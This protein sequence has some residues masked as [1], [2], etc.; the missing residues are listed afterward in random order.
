MPSESEPRQP[1][2]TNA[3]PPGR[4]FPCEKCGAKLDFDPASRSLQCPYCGHTQAIEPSKARVHKHDLES[5]LEKGGDGTVLE[6]RSSQVTCTAC[7]AVVLLEDKVVTDKCPYC[8][9]H[10][11]NK[12]EAAKAMIAPE[13]VIP[14]AITSRQAIEAYDRWLKGL[15]FAPNALRHVATLGQ[16]SGAYVPFWTFDSMTYTHYT[17]QRGEDYTETETYTETNAQGQTETKTRQVTKTRWYHVSGEVQH[18]FQ[19]I[20]ICASKGVPEHYARTLRPRDLKAL[21]AFRSEFLSGFKTERYTIGPSD[22]FEEAKQ[23]MDGEIRELC[24]RDIGGD[25]QRVESVNTQHVGVTYKHILLP[26]W[27]ASYRY[28]E[29]SYRVLV[30][31]QTG[32]VLGDR[33]YSWV[34]IAILVAV[35]LAA[36]LAAF[37]LFT[38]LARGAM[39]EQ[40]KANRACYSPSAALSESK[41]PFVHCHIVHSIYSLLLDFLPSHP[42]KATF[43]LESWSGLV[44]RA[45]QRS[46]PTGRLVPISPERRAPCAPVST[47][48]FSTLPWRS[49]EHCWE[50]RP[51]WEPDIPRP[52]MKQLLP[53]RAS[54]WPNLRSAAWA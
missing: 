44:I 27:L 9:T 15:W 30:N 45:S 29:K 50:R 51:R 38:S 54:K 12:P 53:S 28:Q 13:G 31:G 17:G 7:G 3:P 46:G 2:I 14:F 39:V 19:D 41:Q 35:I 21:E 10:L 18:F 32:E 25:H 22:G 37:L 20:F 6:G 5:A 34:K 42:E 48:T 49:A 43:P 33:P 36:V 47:A 26:I 52:K 23:I 1:T 4:K 16:T 24:R 40:P 8:S 11:E